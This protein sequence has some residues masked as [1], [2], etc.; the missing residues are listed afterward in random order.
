M[1]QVLEYRGSADIKSYFIQHNS[2]YLKFILYQIHIE[3]SVAIIV[4]RVL[5]C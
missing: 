3:H 2:K 4:R 1:Y 5:I